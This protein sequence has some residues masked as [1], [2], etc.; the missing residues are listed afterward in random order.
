MLKRCLSGILALVLT[1]G[2]FVAIPQEANAATVLSSSAALVDTLKSME[3][4]SSQPFWD[5]AQWT[6]GYGTKCPDDKLEEYKKNGITHA[7]AQAL[8]E[9]EL[10][11]AENAINK[12]TAT[13]GLTLKQNEFDAL[14]SFTYNCG[15]GWTQETDGYFNT[16][17]RNGD[18][19]NAFLYGM[20]LWST[21]GGEYI[22]I[23][24]R[25]C[26]ANMY[27]NGEYRAPNA[28][29]TL[30][31]DNFRWVFLDGNGGNTYYEIYAFDSDNP[32]PINAALR[33]TPTGTDKNGKEFSYTFAGWYTA[34]GQEITKLDNTVAR[35]QR[36][37]AKWVDPE[38]KA[39]PM[40]SKIPL[41]T[42]VV[43]T[44][45]NVNLR[46]GPSTDYTKV[47]SVTQDA[48]LTL[49]EVTLTDN[50]Y[51]GKTNNGW[52]RLDYTSYQEGPVI[53]RQP[54][55]ATAA[56][57]TTA[58]IT[59]EAVGVGLKYQWYVAA[60]GSSKFNKSS[61]TKSTYS[62]KMSDSRNNRR[63][64]C[65][66][67]DA[68]GN[69]VQS[70]TATLYM[71][72]T[73]AVT[74]QPNSTYAQIGKTATVKV[75]ASGSSLKY[76][77]YY[78]EKDE[79]VFKTSSVTSASYKAVMSLARHG[80]K[81]Y[82]EITDKNGSKVRTR[83]V[84]ISS[85]TAYIIDQPTDA[86]VSAN[87]QTATV[88]VEAAGKNLSYQWY[89]CNPG[90]SKFSKSSITKDTY[91]VKMTD[92]RNGRKLYCV[93][94]DG[95]G[96]KLT[97]DT[98][99]MYV[100]NPVNIVQQ[101]AS[102][103]VADGEMATVQVTAKGEGL[104]YQW[105]ICNPGSS[106]FSKSSITKD[107]YNVKMTDS[108]DGRKLYCVVTD[109]NGKKLTSN[110]VTLHKD[111]CLYITCQP[112]TASALEGEY[113][114][115]QVVANGEGLTYQWYVCKAGSTKYYKS[116]ITTDTYRTKMD[117]DRNGRTVYCVI[118]DAKGNTVTSDTVSLI[119]QTP[120]VITKQPQNVSVA[121][122]KTAKTTVEATGD[123]LTYTWYLRQPGN[124]TFGRSSITENTYSVKMTDSRNGRQIYCVITDAYGNTVTTE[125]VTLSMQSATEETTTPTETTA[126]TQ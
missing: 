14:V 63:V 55:S 53:T 38:G 9:K 43:V 30:Y 93:I 27:I 106:K 99:T 42:Q 35:G 86:V 65:V 87:G 74:T 120:L 8:L 105:Y 61:I 64:Y 72:T 92:S 77:W 62:V 26:E 78:C 113:A 76:R 122:G 95:S 115:T 31:P 47:G 44:A 54:A 81:L 118:T 19:S 94:T 71:G 56:K 58:Q 23:D 109:A 39:L 97:T 3:G 59:L 69:S 70:D 37:Y 7:E 111:R 98:V 11:K 17:V 12:F 84:T 66:I 36:L 29:G 40:P 116:S 68:A 123:G 126:P 102:V 75:N 96:N 13:Y 49:T 125:T 52:L 91:S 45:T 1:L 20:L 2:L 10:N 18:K 21:A 6:V 5:Y 15:T 121:N 22:L 73:L 112:E 85:A 79:N 110:T 117:A 50:Y 90:S 25:M 48:V 88:Q 82:C 41:P 80:R 114:T 103:M 34:E 83:V 28:G 24:R 67:T 101:P 108:R 32:Q 124:A 16:A 46:S 33:T 57:G 119:L 104:K 100:N 51:W 89:I 107:T 60:A 4:F